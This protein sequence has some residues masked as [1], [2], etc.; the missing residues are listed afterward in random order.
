MGSNDEVRMT[1]DEK[2][3]ISSFG[4]RHSYLSFP[5]DGAQRYLLHPDVTPVEFCAHRFV[6]VLG[7]GRP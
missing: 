1:N 7:P 4:L 5:K 3:R 2:F 6:G